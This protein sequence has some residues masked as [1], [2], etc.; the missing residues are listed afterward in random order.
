M[1]AVGSMFL[2]RFAN[3]AHIWL[4]QFVSFACFFLIRLNSHRN[5][6]VLDRAPLPTLLAPG[7]CV[8]YLQPD[9]QGRPRFAPGLIIGI[10]RA[11][12][13]GATFGSTCD[14]DSV[15]GVALPSLSPQM[16]T[17]SLASFAAAA[18]PQPQPQSQLTQS[19]LLPPSSG[20]GHSGLA[21]VFS[22]AGRLDEVGAEPLLVMVQSGVDGVVHEVLATDLRLAPSGLVPLSF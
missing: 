8:L 21:R 17:S 22:F 15:S 10:G 20:T 19:P 7:L 11:G 18:P 16:S 12:T 4:L 2:V 9:W 5:Q 3:L 14:S 6:M 1:P 13:M